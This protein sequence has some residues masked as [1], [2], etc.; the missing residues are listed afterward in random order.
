MFTL[1]HSFSR[2]STRL[3]AAGITA[4]VIGG[5]TYGIVERHLEG[6]SSA[7]ATPSDDSS[8]P[9]ATCRLRRTSRIRRRR[10]ERSIRTRRRRIGRNSQQPVRL[11]LHADDTHRWK[12][13]RQEDVVYRHTRTARPPRRRAPS[14]TARPRSC[15]ERPTARRSQ[16]PRSSCSRHKPIEHRV[17]GRRVHPRHVRRVEDRWPDPV[18]LQARNRQ[19]PQR[20]HGQQGNRSRIA[21]LPRRR[22]RSRRPAQQ[23]RLRGPQHRRQLAP[24]HLREHRLQSHRRQRLQSKQ[25]SP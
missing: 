18:E 23:R 14:R 22:R 16:P 20:N 2:R 7:A 3:L 5:G 1:K 24:P 15:S 10:I 25:P 21:R 12:G 9:C 19:D 17:A 8:R 6:G 4:I 13:H 11:R